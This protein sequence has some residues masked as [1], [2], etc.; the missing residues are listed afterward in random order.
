[1]KNTFFVL[2][3]LIL[4]WTGIQAQTPFQGT[5]TY[6]MELLGEGMEAYQA[7]MP[8][9]ISISVLKSKTRLEY[10][11]GMMAAMLGTM[12]TDNKKG[13]TY[14]IKESDEMIYV[15]DP[16]KMNE[17]AEDAPEAESVITKEDEVI[18]IAGYSC[19]KYKVVQNGPMG[20][21][22]SYAWVTDK[23][24]MPKSEGSGAGM[25]GGMVSVKGLPGMPLKMMT[26]QGP[27]T[28]ALTAQKVDL[29]TPSKADF[30][31]PKGYKQ[32]PFDPNSL[33]GGG[34]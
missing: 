31:L 21:Q 2:M 16:K 23:Y 11:G 24:V 15:M 22:V 19:Q 32:E 1:M 17:G 3:A 26:E 28:V 30:K 9:A 4:G 20:E 8:S 18:D 5:L 7:M 10:E 12:L 14:M 27:M 33:M 29:T 34:M 25:G 13:I 6:K